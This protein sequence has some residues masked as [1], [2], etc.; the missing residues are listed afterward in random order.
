MKSK[1]A[2][3]PADEVRIPVSAPSFIAFFFLT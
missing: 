1:A 2:K 3:K